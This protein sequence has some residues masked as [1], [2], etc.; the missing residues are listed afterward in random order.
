[1][2]FAPSH[3]ISVSLCRTNLIVAY[4]IG[5][6]IALGPPQFNRLS[7]HNF[8]L[9]PCASHQKAPTIFLFQIVVEIALKKI[10]IAQLFQARG[11][12]H[13]PCRLCVLWI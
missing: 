10:T 9:L 1:L 6:P 4:L 3:F 2:P 13:A 12:G 7:P 11:D 5:E 8:P